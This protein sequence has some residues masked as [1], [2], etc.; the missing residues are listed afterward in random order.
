MNYKEVFTIKKTVADLV[1]AFL[2]IDDI[3]LYSG[4]LDPAS[5][6]VLHVA[7][8]EFEDGLTMYVNARSDEKEY[9]LDYQIQRTD[10]SWF[11]LDAEYDFNDVVF[12]DNGNTYTVHYEIAD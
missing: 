2:D 3:E 11:D 5:D 1:E 10:G 4:D 12:E 7:R 6:D 9:W 8:V